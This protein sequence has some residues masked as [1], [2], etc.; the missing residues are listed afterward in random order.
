MGTSHMW[1]NAVILGAGDEN[2]FPPH[3]SPGQGGTAPP[4]DFEGVVNPLLCHPH[5]LPCITSRSDGETLQ[6]AVRTPEK[7]VSP[8]SIQDIRRTDAE[9]KPSAL[10]GTPPSPLGTVLISCQTA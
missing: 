3:H 1:L 4:Q 8:P 10:R 7:A 2:V 9:G 5:H 6:R